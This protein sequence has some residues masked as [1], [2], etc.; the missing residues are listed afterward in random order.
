V[1][2]VYFRD[3]TY[4][5]SCN[6]EGISVLRGEEGIPLPEEVIQALQEEGWTLESDVLTKSSLLNL[7]LHSEV[8]L[9]LVRAARGG[10]K[11]FRANL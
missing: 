1:I 9:A 11:K 8:S 2:P 4:T 5:L 6:D 10:N 3:H 7:R